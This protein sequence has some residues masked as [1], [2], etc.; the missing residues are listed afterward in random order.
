MRPRRPSRDKSEEAGTLHR[1]D[2]TASFRYAVLTWCLTVSAESSVTAR[3]RPSVVTEA[4]DA[5]PTVLASCHA[6]PQRPIVF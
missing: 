2:A 5:L 6:T 4:S 1:F 3:R